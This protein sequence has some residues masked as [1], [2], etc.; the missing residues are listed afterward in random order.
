MRYC[1]WVIGTFP[2]IHT[3]PD[4]WASKQGQNVDSIAL[5]CEALCWPPRLTACP[6]LPPPKHP[7]AH[8]RPNIRK[9]H[10]APLLAGACLEHAHCKHAAD[11]HTPNAPV[12][13]VCHRALR[14]APDPRVASHRQL[15]R[16][17][18]VKVVCGGMVVLVQ[19]RR[20]ALLRNP[21]A[22]AAGTRPAADRD[23]AGAPVGAA[24]A[25]A[26][27]AAADAAGVRD[28]V[29]VRQPDPLLPVADQ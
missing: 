15:L 24:A 16:L 21:A 11:K 29:N 23:A 27:G 20:A 6:A 2:S 7:H 9:A 22:A 12:S 17:L 14:A 19:Q 13:H 28:G 3:H 18:Q 5:G 4:S 10:P 26:V 8:L 25:A 1:T